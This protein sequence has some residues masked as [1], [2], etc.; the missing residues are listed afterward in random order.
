[1]ITGRHFW[2]RIFLIWEVSLVKL[3]VCFSILGDYYSRGKREERRGGEGR[4]GKGRGRKE[5]VHLL[6]MC[7]GHVVILQA[8]HNHF[9]FNSKRNHKV[10][11]DIVSYMR[12][13]HVL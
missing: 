10:L 3:Q 1:M 5:V 8:L 7:V 9:L 13:S 11:Y 12:R 4:G 6:K 2:G